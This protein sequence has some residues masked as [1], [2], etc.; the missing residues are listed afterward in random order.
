MMG[1]LNVLT[2]LGLPEAL[3]N[4]CRE[5]LEEHAASIHSAEPTTVGSVFGGSEQ[6]ALLEHHTSIAHQHVAEALKQMTEGLRGYAENLAAFDKDLQE[7]DQEAAAALT[8]SRKRELAEI[9]S[10]LNSDDFHNTGG[11]G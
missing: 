4:S 6:S 2:V 8:P 9:G 1:P 10:R 7:R 11:E 3:V 5:I